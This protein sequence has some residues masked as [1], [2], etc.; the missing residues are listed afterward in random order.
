MST[1]QGKQVYSVTGVG[2]VILAMDGT[3][4]NDYNVS[5]LSYYGTG[6]TFDDIVYAGNGDNVNLNLITEPGYA[7]S[8]V[9]YTPAGGTATAIT[10][11]EENVYTF[12]MP[13]ANVTINANVTLVSVFREIEGYGDGDGKWAFI[14][15]PVEGSI[16]PAEVTNLIGHAIPETNPVVYDFDL[17]RFNPNANLEWENY[18]AHTSD[19]NIINGMGYLYATK[20]T[21][22]LT[23]SGSFNTGTSKDVTGLPAGF[24]LVGNPF[25]VDAY[26]SKSY[27]TL[28]GDGSAI[29][30]TTSDAVIPPCYGVIVQVDGS[31][32]VTFTTAPT[33]QNAVNNGGLQIA[34]SQVPE[35]VEGP[36]R[37][38]GGVSTGS[39]TA[40]LDNAIVSFNEGEQLGKFYF[41]NQNANI[42]LPQNGKDYAIAYS[43]RAGEMPVNFKAK[44]NG[45]YTITVKPEGVEMSYL[46]LIDNMT[47]ADIDLLAPSVPE[48]V[49]GP[50]ASGTGPSTLRRVQGSGTSYTFTAKTTDY[51]S[52]FKLV[53]VTNNEDGPSTGSGTE[54]SGTFA[55]ISNG[56][57]ILTAGADDAIL[58]IVDVMGRVLVSRDALNASPISTTGM[59]PG[60]YVL[61]L[62]NGDDVKTQKIIIE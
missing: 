61:R 16:A 37:D 11:D 45:Q 43:D 23:F 10:P 9:T 56:N 33:Q 24:N 62:I 19:F 20:E 15:S 18:H 44:E 32:T 41:G 26:V 48:P 39:T 22:T 29:L 1:K 25:T 46:H 52:R 49:E 53:F 6:L 31:E 13:D 2:N 42:Y 28:N 36:A 27:Y 12:T 30:T 59:T 58:Q 17:Y 8:N 4:T 40:T 47:G 3:I 35:L 34:V 21:K 5:G 60:V 7:V 14:S 57:I 38:K 55:F 51:A 54:G 50:N